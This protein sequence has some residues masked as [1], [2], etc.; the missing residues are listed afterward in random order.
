MFV[1]RKKE[2]AYLKEQFESEGRCAVLVYG[3]RRVGKSTLISQAAAGQGCAV[4]NFL[5]VQSSYRGNMELLSRCICQCLG[6]PQVRFDTIMDVFAFLGSLKKK[7]ILVLDEYQ[8]LKNSGTKGEVDSY[9]QAVIDSLPPSVKLVLCGS[10]ISV[11]KEL[12]EEGNPLFGRFSG[13]VHLRE[14]DYFDASGFYKD[15]SVY[16]KIE[17]YA[18]FGGSPYVLSVIDPYADIREIIEKL[19]LP[20]TGI[21]HIY[22]E[23]VMLKEIQKAYDV[24]ILQVLG[25]GK[26]KYSEIKS[27]MD[28]SDN[29]LL[30]K[31]LKNLISMETISKASPI[32]R[33]NDSRKQFY[34]INDN[35][36]RL[37]FTYVFANDG[38]IRTLGEKNFYDQYMDKSIKEFIARR[39]EDIARQ[40]LHRLIVNGSIKGARNLGSLWY[41]NAATHTNGEFDCVLER[42]AGYDFYECKFYDHA[43]S[44]AECLK[45]AEQ[46]RGL[47]S[48]SIHSIGF[49]CTG[50]FDFESDEYSLINAD[51]MFASELDDIVG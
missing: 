47:D 39:F 49:I 38:I 18:L 10:Y 9:M 7:I 51:E 25:N 32:N 44:R 31:Q 46:I 27:F 15:A 8:Y 13:V 3:K 11:M 40:Y 42:E 21:L 33:V 50:G 24:R 45:E 19:L 43:M 17:N 12:L 36:M 14:M 41:D 5:C 28:A 35:L 22:I 34:S 6:L 48:L 16:H 26:K 30:D 4:I 23:N 29:G 37:Y 1:G 2:I 20:E